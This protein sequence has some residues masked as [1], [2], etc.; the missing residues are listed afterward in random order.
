VPDHVLNEAQRL[1]ELGYSCEQVRKEMHVARR[2][3]ER[4]W[5]RTNVGPT[6]R[7]KIEKAV[8]PVKES[9]FWK[10]HGLGQV[11]EY[12]WK[13]CP[14]CKAKVIDGWSFL[15]DGDCPQYADDRNA[16]PRPAP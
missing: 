8:S 14:T 3:I 10:S 4:Y 11:D 1:R 13:R 5:A 12:A 7:E 6:L 15:H 2:T 9:A 16:H